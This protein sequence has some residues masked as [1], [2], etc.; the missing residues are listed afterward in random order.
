MKPTLKIPHTF[1]RLQRNHRFTQETMHS[2][3]HTKNE[4]ACCN[5]D[6]DVH[7]AQFVVVN[8]LKWF[9]STT[10]KE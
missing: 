8:I 5:L 7:I 4:A 10:F 6:Y 9:T 3:D 1:C 2:C